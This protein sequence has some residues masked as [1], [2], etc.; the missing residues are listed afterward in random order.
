MGAVGVD[1]DPV[2]DEG[3]GPAQAVQVSSQENPFH[4]QVSADFASVVAFVPPKV[5][6]EASPASTPRKPA[7]VT[8]TVAPPAV[9]G[10]VLLQMGTALPLVQMTSLSAFTRPA[11]SLIS[12]GIRSARRQP[13]LCPVVSSAPHSVQADPL[14]V[15]VS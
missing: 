8:V 2:G 4:S 13:R 11:I 9:I 5:T 7:P 15:P 1:V 14:G 12:S 10:L 6:A 3:E